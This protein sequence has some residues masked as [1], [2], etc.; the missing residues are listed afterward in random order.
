LPLS[1]FFKFLGSGERQTLNR[2]VALLDMAIDSSQHLLILVQDLKTYDYDS[3]EKE[4]HIIDDL[5]GKTDDEHRALVRTICT[6]SYFGGIREDLL[7]LL[8]VIDNIPD[9][10]KHAA[11]I[12]RDIQLSK[13]VVDYFFM[14]DVGSFIS[15]CIESVKEFKETVLALEKN[16]EDV[17]SLAEKVEAKEDGADEKHHSIVRHLYKN[18][19]NAKSLDIIMLKDFLTTV[20]DIADN[21][22][23]GSDILLILVAKGY[24]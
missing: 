21:A 9:S 11:E 5:E 23:H 18:E 12:F 8:E 20:D 24:S 13:E 2:V 10:A 7:S 15:T 3:V 14:E 22:E 17:L 16:K 19:I 6:G 4:F 1:D